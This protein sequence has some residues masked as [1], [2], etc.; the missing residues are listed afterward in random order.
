MAPVRVLPMASLESAPPTDVPAQLAPASLTTIQLQ[1]Q[2]GEELGEGTSGVVAPVVAATDGGRYV[3][4]RLKSAGPDSAASFAHEIRLHKLC[5]ADCGA[6]VRYAFACQ[7]PD[8][9]VVLMEACDAI[10]WDA[11]A[12]GA[13]WTS[14]AG[15]QPSNVEREAWTRQ[16]CQA[17]DHC[18]TL[19]VVHRDLNPWNVFLCWDRPKRS[20]SLRLGDFGL[21]VQLSRDVTELTGVDA[22]GGAAALDESAL[23]SLYS[24][25]ELGARYGFPAD[26]FSLGMTLLATWTSADCNCNEDSVTEAVETA[27][28]AAKE[29]PHQQ[30]PKL[31]AAAGQQVMIVSMLSGD[32]TARPTAQDSYNRLAGEGLGHPKSGRTSLPMWIFRQCTARCVKAS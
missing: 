5:S 9:L 18:H 31:E 1:L 24:A 29:E 23:G 21:A 32:P 7:T 28:L 25:P 11:I 4:K 30:F 16:L 19:R 26:V 8:E 20:A 15:R 10:L 17:V 6:V 2:L 3:A 14:L 27:K 13:A 12:G 22:V